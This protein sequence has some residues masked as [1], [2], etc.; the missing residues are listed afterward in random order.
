MFKLFKSSCARNKY[1]KQ[2]QEY[3]FQSLNNKIKPI[4]IKKKKLKIKIKT[5]G[6][7]YTDK[8]LVKKN[9][10]KKNHP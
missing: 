5:H 8:T 6:F 4:I 10:N 2:E 1:E 9:N 7:M 3:S